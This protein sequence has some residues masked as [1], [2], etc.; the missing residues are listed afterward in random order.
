M[1][2]LPLLAYGQ[3]PVGAIILMNSWPMYLADLLT[4]LMLIRLPDLILIQGEL[5]LISLISS[6][7][8]S[9]TN[10]IIFVPMLFIFPC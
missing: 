4:L 6:M 9:L 2:I 1:D 5:K 3:N 10:S 8:L 7:V